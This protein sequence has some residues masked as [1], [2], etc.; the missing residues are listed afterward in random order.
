MLLHQS[1][2]RCQPVK[3]LQDTQLVLFA[4][5]SADREA[6][7]ASVIRIRSLENLHVRDRDSHIVRARLADRRGV[8]EALH[9][10]IPYQIGS[11]GLHLVTGRVPVLRRGVR[12]DQA[13]LICLEEELQHLVISPFLVGQRGDA[14]VIADHHGTVYFL[15]I[16]FGE[17]VNVF[18]GGS[19]PVLPHGD[20]VSG[21][22]GLI[23][24]MRCLHVRKDLKQVVQG[25]QLRPSQLRIEIPGKSGHGARRFRHISG[26]AV[27]VHFR[28][29]RPYAVSD[30]F[31]E[32]FDLLPVLHQVG[33]ILDVAA[34]VRHQ[35]NVDTLHHIRIVQKNDISQISGR[36]PGLVQ[37]LSVS[38]YLRSDDVE[39]QIELILQD[40]AE[41]T[42][43]K[44]L[45]VGR[46]IINLQCQLFVMVCH[47]CGSTVL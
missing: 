15:S 42:G 9:P 44:S 1:F 13:H 31:I 10:V 23:G 27:G 40:L 17:L 24:R 28:G 4:H 39:D 25:V 30:P 29:D 35:A 14:V 2:R 47:R 38:G 19:V 45:I 26:R 16:P 43:L 18:N 37:G 12:I 34:D 22:A 3:E 5:L 21:I 46:H 11:L 20:A 36:R 7:S 33:V 8:G 41:P 32:H 6:A